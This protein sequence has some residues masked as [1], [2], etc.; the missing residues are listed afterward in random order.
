MVTVFP[1]LVAS[2]ALL[3]GNPPRPEPNVPRAAAFEATLLT[4]PHRRVR[5]T[6]PRVQKW[7]VEGVRRSRT[8]A[9]LVAAINRTDVIV[10]V[11][12]VPTLPRTVSGRLLLVPIT[13]DQRYLRIQ[14]H[15]ESVEREAIALVGHELRHAL[16]IAEATDVRNQDDMLRLYRRIGRPEVRE[17]SY[18]TTAAQDAGRQ[19][20]RELA[21]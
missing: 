4:S 2:L 7:L 19:V 5:T 18:D 20:R 6:N 14:V 17:H 12:I 13:H 8:F 10:Y 1:V 15:R 9:S 3:G 16:E 11:E 21:G